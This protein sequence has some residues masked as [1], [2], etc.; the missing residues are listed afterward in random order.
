MSVDVVG[1]VGA[2]VMG[3]G[4]AQALAQTGHRVILVDVSATALERARAGLKKNLRFHRML[5]EAGTAPCVDQVL[6]PSPSRRITMRWRRRSSSSRTSPRVGHQG[7]RPRAAERDLPAHVPFAV[8]VGDLDH[9]HR[10]DDE[11]PGAR[12]RHALQNP[13]R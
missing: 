3:T 13:V 1:V 6:S 11:P 7:G 9:P 10:L 12:R 2:G 4:V 8:N 5:A